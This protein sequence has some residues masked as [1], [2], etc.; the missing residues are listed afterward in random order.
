MISNGEWKWTVALVA[1]FAIPAAV[2]VGIA[3]WCLW[4]ERKMRKHVGELDTAFMV[5]GERLA[6]AEVDIEA[7]IQADH[8]RMI[9]DAVQKDASRSRASTAMPGPQGCPESGAP[10]GQGRGA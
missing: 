5:W 6:G 10:T 2:V 7:L 8:E 3:G 4:R 1:P 9:D